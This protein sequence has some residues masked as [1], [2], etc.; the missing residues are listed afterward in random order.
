MDH[1]CSGGGQEP[2]VAA[3]SSSSESRVTH[4]RGS[5]LGFVGPAFDR[6][7]EDGDPGPD[8]AH[9]FC[10]ALERLPRGSDLDKGRYFRT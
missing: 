4:G 9:L 2:A 7:R 5:A 8:A 6:D 10:L 1:S 3:V